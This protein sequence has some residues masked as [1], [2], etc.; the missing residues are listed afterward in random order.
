MSYISLHSSEVLFCMAAIEQGKRE[1]ADTSPFTWLP[2]LGT[3]AQRCAVLPT[4][5]SST[6]PPSVTLTLED[7][8][9]LKARAEGFIQ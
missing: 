4:L 9:E 2:A 6:A 5:S 1:R 3:K 7:G 8:M